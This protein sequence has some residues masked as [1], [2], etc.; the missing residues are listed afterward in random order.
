MFVPGSMR[1]VTLP[2]S[3]TLKARPRAN[4]NPARVTMKGA[5]CALPMRSPWII[6]MPEHTAN[7]T[8]RAGHE[9][10]REA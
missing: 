1:W 6:P 5:S 3:D 7:G 9:P 8:S 10:H 4:S 2:L